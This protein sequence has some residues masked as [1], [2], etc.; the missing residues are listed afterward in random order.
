M[1]GVR[2]GTSGSVCIVRDVSLSTLVLPHTSSSSRTGSDDTD[3]AEASSVCISPDRSAPGSP[4]E[5]SPG[6]GSTTSH[7]PTVAGQS[8]VHIFNIS[9]RQASSGAPRQEG[10]SV[11]SRGLDI[12]PPTRTVEI[13]GGL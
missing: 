6:P 11:P 2:P 3:V 10:A 12:S 7:C 4:G 9:S 8:M 1:D 5:S 13:V